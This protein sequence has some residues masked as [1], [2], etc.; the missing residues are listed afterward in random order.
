[1]K[2]MPSK[3]LWYIPI[4]PHLQWLSRCTSLAQFMDNH[5]HNRSQDDIMWMLVDGSAFKDIEDMW[6]ILKEEPHNPKLSLAANS[7]NP[8]GEIRFVY[9]ACP[10]FFY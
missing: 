1:M 9:S 5:A 2:K 8:F 6:P 7:V 3:V 4:I 10:N